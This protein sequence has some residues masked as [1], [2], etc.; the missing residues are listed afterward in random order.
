V[1]AESALDEI[2]R[3]H[4]D[5]PQRA[6]AGL[7]A[8][9]ASTL[10]ADR[11]PLLAFLWAH[12][13]GEKL[14]AWDEAAAR[15]E[16]LRASLADAPLAFV[17]HAAVAAYCAGRSSNAALATLAA[18]GG[19]PEA[20]VLVRLNALDRQPPAAATALAAALTREAAGAAAFD[21]GNAL[22]QR[23]AIAFNN[24]TTRLL[25]L[26]TGPVV[27]E[28][29]AAALLDGSAAAL[30]FWQAAGTWVNVERALYLR[31]LVY[32]RIGQ[33]AAARDACRQALDI[34]DAH[35]E[36]A[37]DRVFLQLQLAA[38]L[39]RLGEAAEGKGRLAEARAA[40]AGWDDPGLRSWFADEH[41]RL[42]GGEQ[43]VP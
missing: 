11:L 3:I 7:R 6:A 40:A 41:D 35:G 20:E 30:R 10:P 24:A 38:A 29:T 9:D 26:A 17:V 14:G 27:D 39:L 19:R 16:Q 31:A 43:E 23:L 34:I 13:V 36:Q 15:L 5:E 2:D 33:P 8:L 21:A 32:N 25:D 28:T 18:A 37:V 1:N 22:N 4:D 12:V 42:F